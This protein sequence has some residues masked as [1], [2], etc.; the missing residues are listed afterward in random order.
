MSTAKKII[1]TENMLQKMQNL[2]EQEAQ[3][4]LHNFV[5]IIHDILLHLLDE[6]NVKFDLKIERIGL[7]K[8]K[9]TAKKAGKIEAIKFLIWYEKEY[10]KLKDNP[11]FAKFLEREY[12]AN[13]TKPDIIR[14]CSTLLSETKRIIY[15]AY[16]NF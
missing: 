15:S 3:V 2:S 13:E 14:I 1:D 11:E 16:E 7:E 9:S 6:Y 4:E 10:K 5:K 8:F 12:V